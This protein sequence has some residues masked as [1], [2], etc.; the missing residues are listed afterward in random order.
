[1]CVN[2][3]QVH[4]LPLKIFRPFNLW[5]DQNFRQKIAPDFF[6]RPPNGTCHVFRWIPHPHLLLYY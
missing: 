4:G 2:F 1:L 5:P 3:H 6:R